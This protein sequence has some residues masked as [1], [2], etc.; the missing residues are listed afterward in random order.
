MPCRQHIKVHCFERQR[1]E[2][3]IQIPP[4]NE[5]GNGLLAREEVVVLLNRGEFPCNLQLWY[6]LF[7]SDFEKNMNASEIAF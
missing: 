7:I 1:Q 5:V 2:I 3:G 6:E 4:L